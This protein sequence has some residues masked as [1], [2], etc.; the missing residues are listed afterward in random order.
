[1]I[2]RDEKTRIENQQ[3]LVHLASLYK[4]MNR[5][6][7]A[8][9]L[10]RDASNLLPVNGNPK[11][12]YVVRM[13]EVLD[14]PVGDVAE[15]IWGGAGAATTAKAEEE[16]FEK[17]DGAATEA[18]QR[19]EYGRMCEF[20]ERMAAAARTPDQ[21]ALAALREA[22]GWDGLGRYTRLLEAVRRGLNENPSSPDVRLLLEVN[23]A[24]AHYTLWHLFESRAMARDLIEGFKQD[25]PRSRR[26]CAAQAFAYYIIGNTYRRLIVKEPES[27]LQ[28]ARVACEALKT[29]ASLYTQL[30][31]EF[32]HDP[33]RGIANT[34][35]GGIIEAEVALGLRRPE[36]AVAVISDALDAV[37]DA[38]DRLV[39]DRLESYGWWCIFGCNI[40]VRHLTERELQQRVATFTKE[41]YQIADRLNNWA[42]RERLFTLEFLQREQLN[43]L[44]GIPVDW[45]IDSEAVRAI[46]GTMGRFPA[47]RT[48]AW[49][50]LQAATVVESV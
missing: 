50:I 1:M 48:T 17:L 23:F 34:C 28:C 6:E 24:N 38:T 40:A 22:G 26:A 13:A 14:W 20:A 30:A 43:D 29:S 7:L 27:C 2:K 36:E 37:S 3:R 42:M 41:G 21:R 10:G 25:P 8:E 19:G 33:W 35:R 9:A 44:A 12:D 4:R 46:V 16:D 47:F 5:R 15:A 45:T 49:R 32:D 39:G 18:H 11:L 31:E